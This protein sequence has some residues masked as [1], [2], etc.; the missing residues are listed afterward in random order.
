M[1]WLLFAVAL[2]AAC[3]DSSGFSPPGVRPT[4]VK[5][6]G[7][8]D[9][10]VSCDPKETGGACGLPITV[11]FRLPADQFV[12]KAYVRFQGDG[13]DTGIDHGYLLDRQFGKG[14]ATDVSVTIQ[15]AIPPAILRP[16]ALFTYTVRLV[17][18]AGEESDEST[19]TV[20][21]Q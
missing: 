18:G 14:E 20:S 12:W 11:T 21:V 3:N 5:A 4:I 15:A 8:K 10:T 19:L 16:S 6:A 1:R 17:T 7:P 9:A 2:L 13:G